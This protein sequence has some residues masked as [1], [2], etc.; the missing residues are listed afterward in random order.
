M[1]ELFVKLHCW[2]RESP[3]VINVAEEPSESRPIKR[4]GKKILPP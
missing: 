1:R 3:G 4:L 2:G